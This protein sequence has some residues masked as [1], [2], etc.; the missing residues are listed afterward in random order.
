MSP[1]NPKRPP[2]SPRPPGD[3]AS[4]PEPEVELPFDDDEVAPLQ[5]DDPRPQR[6]PQFPAGPR[7]RPRRGPAG[8]P[9]EG[10]DRELPTRFDSGEYEDP[11]HTPAF[12]YVERGPGV[13]QLLPVKQGVLVLG[14]ASN[15]DLRLQHPSISRRHAQL[16]RRGDHLT[17]KDLGSQNGTYVNRTRLSGEVELRSGDELALG[18][19][20]LQLRGPGPA[21]ARPR[22]SS[23]RPGSS[24][25]VGLGSRRILL[26]AVATGALVAVFLT[27]AAMRFL[28][29]GGEPAP[30]AEVEAVEA[31]QVAEVPADVA[32][33]AEARPVEV[34]PALEE[35]H[36]EPEA[37][38]PVPAAPAP[39]LRS[40]SRAR[41]LSAQ[42]IAESSP[43]PSKPRE[44]GGRVKAGSGKAAV[45]PAPA[46]PQAGLVS[47]PEAEAE[48]LARYEAGNV[49]SALSLARRAQL[50][51]LATTLTRFQEE[52]RAGNAALASGD[53]SSAVQH[54]SAALELDQRISKGWGALAP[55]I[56]KAL[57]QAQSQAGS[58]P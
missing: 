20:L 4:R 3:S 26:L 32:P 15:S 21:P 33:E 10:R 1:P 41:P 42:A 9:R 5:A 18:N 22:S 13:G 36:P 34:A 45:K 38:A 12:L 11:G 16:T 29:M 49:D 48:A 28:R 8:A 24:L 46:E 27:L 31:E 19:A 23:S 2:R 39:K 7:R 50:E 53:P 47:N 35:A 40:P 54:L 56:R 44:T 43:S 51:T 37:T 57:A 52:W 14:R 58:T 6:V 30:S 25:R 17:L 55:K